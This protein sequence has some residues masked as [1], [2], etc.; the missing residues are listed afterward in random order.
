MLLLNNYQTLWPFVLW[1]MMSVS[2]ITHWAFYT[3]PTPLS[4]GDLK[5]SSHQEADLGVAAHW[6]YKDGSKKAN[7]KDA[8]QYRWL[9]ELLDILEQDQQRP[10]DF[11]ENT[12]LELFQDK[13]FV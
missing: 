8:K 3:L 12:K 2:V 1:L 11:L 7:I 5:I 9:R 10:E 13:V 6:A 4:P